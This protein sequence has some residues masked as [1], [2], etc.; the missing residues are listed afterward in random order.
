MGRITAQD[1]DL[2]AFLRLIDPVWKKLELLNGTD[3]RKTAPARQFI[4]RL[5]SL[6]ASMSP[7]KFSLVL[8][9]PLSTNGPT[10]EI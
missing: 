4:V 7:E 5:V 9:L 2:I 6:N 3:E 8:A 10:G 1:H